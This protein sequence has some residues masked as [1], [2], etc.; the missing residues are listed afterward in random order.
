MNSWFSLFYSKR[1]QTGSL[2]HDNDNYR[3]VVLSAAAALTVGLAKFRRN[4]EREHVLS[5]WQDP[6]TTEWKVLSRN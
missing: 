1:F 3:N 5:Q 6:E 4:N 2:N